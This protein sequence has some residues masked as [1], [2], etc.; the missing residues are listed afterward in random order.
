[1]RVRSLTG[2]DHALDLVAEIE[3]RMSRPVLGYGCD[4]FSRLDRF[5]IIVPQRKPGSREQRSVQR[6]AGS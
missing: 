4:Q 5:E 1:L 3:I 6:I 2:L